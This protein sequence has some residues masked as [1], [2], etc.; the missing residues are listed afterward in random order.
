M[1]GQAAR[2]DPT[3]PFAA[4][5]FTWQDQLDFAAFSG[6]ANPLHVDPIAARRTQA[7]APVVH[8]IHSLLWAIDSLADYRQDLKPV[9]AIKAHF[10]KMIYVGDQVDVRLGKATDSTL[11]VDLSVGDIEVAALTLKFGPPVEAP[12]PRLEAQPPIPGPAEP[13]DHGLEDNEGR[14][15]RLGFHT[16]V[17]EAARR[18]PEAARVLGARRIA[19]L[20]CTTYLVG[21]VAPGLH[22]IYGSLNL[23]LCEESDGVEALD[24]V[25]AAVDPR[26]RLIRLQV[27]G[28]GLSGSLETYGRL[29]PTRQ[30]G[31]DDLR[32]LVAPD[33]FAG[34]VALI[35]GASRGLGE[36]AAKLVAA[37]GGRV[38]LTY[39]VGRDEAEAVSAE[40]VRAGGQADVVAYDA[41]AEPARQLADLATPPTHIYYFATP[42]IF[43]RKPK[44]FSVERFDDF[45]AVYVAGFLRLMEWALQA[46]TGGLSVF[47]PS[48][49]AVAERPADMTEYAMSKAAGEILCT[50]LVR[51]FKGLNILVERLPRLPT[52]QTAT[53]VPV[54]TESALDVML[55]IVR[56][57]Q[58]SGTRA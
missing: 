55:P 13:A 43:R 49:I 58:A 22:S 48:S 21:M 24:F 17:A 29:P 4:R 20:A 3:G 53:L 11:R 41:R 1:V 28:G 32:R 35:V 16:S 30:I 9:A 54:K 50:D 18:F 27:Q 2:R 38:I 7:G 36:V 52:D 47:Y 39:A 42:S 37:G 8:G 25:V 40:I 46:R 12:T 45:N 6:D 23:S 51:S 5:V 56:A 19:A 34:A 31:M 14:R 26:F 15:G 44:L 57:V 10:A 33:A